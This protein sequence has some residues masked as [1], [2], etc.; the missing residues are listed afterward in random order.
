MTRSWLAF[1]HLIHLH[2][3]ET[4]H[5]AEWLI[6]VDRF[7][8]LYGCVDRY[9]R[10]LLWKV[11]GEQS[12]VGLLLSAASF[13]R[14]KFQPLSDDI[15]PNPPASPA[16]WRSSERFM[17]NCDRGWQS[18]IKRES[19]A[20]SALRHYVHANETLWWL[21]RAASGRRV[22]CTKHHQKCIFRLFLINLLG[23]I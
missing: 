8:R 4:A 22:L 21:R 14:N 7:R 20:L 19:S 10:L 18:E 2:F 12:A 17:A 1:I 3:C 16:V 5:E 6:G 11:R 9:A 15:H 23:G 13:L